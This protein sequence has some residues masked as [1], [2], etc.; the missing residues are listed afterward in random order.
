MK[1]EATFCKW[2][3]LH[4]YCAVCLNRICLY[5]TLELCIKY[6]DQRYFIKL[7]FFNKCRKKMI[8][9]EK[10]LHNVPKNDVFTT[11]SIANCV[12]IQFKS[13]WSQTLTFCKILLRTD[14][15]C[16]K[17]GSDWG[18]WIYSK[19]QMMPQNN[20]WME[21]TW[22][23]ITKNRKMMLHRLLYFVLVELFVSSR[24]FW[25]EK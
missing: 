22:C 14:N 23:L 17:E 8:K 16:I 7:E 19:V 11:Q 1:W 9:I 24:N 21:C 5:C 2:L 13:I 20:V 12:W 6:F 25:W 3:L 10:I 18:I 4:D 15:F